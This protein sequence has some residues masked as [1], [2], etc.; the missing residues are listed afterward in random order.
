MLPL[1]NRPRSQS[2]VYDF[3]DNVRFS[4]D[5]QHAAPD[6]SL[7]EEQYF[8]GGG[9]TPVPDQLVSANQRGTSTTLGY[10]RAGNTTSV[11]VA[12][13]PSGGGCTGPCATVYSYTWDEVGRMQSATRA[14]GDTPSTAG[15][16]VAMDYTST[17]PADASPST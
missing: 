1:A 4:D 6:R 9:L 15:V 8:L 17:H 12:R 14:D 13:P 2:Y 5:D 3:L 7:G 11:T 10:D 16:S